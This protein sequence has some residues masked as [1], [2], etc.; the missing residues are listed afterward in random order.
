MT[1]SD[2]LHALC[3]LPRNINQCVHRKFDLLNMKVFV[4]ARAITPLC[5]DRE[6]R[7]RRAAHEQQYVNMSCLSALTQ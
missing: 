5:N 2:L 7:L 4:Q 6:E 3:S 1:E